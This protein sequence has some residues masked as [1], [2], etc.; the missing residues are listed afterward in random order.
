MLSSHVEAYRA[1]QFPIIVIACKSDLQ[2]RV[3]P[4]AAS[5]ALQQY[6]V[7]LVEVSHGENGRGKMRRSFD[8][9]L[10]AILR[11]RRQGTAFFCASGW[12]Y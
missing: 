6:D 8:Y 9:L 12:V 7:G 5:E 1:F 4:S 10:R 2:K 3:D 11:E